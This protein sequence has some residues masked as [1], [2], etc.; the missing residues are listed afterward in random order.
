MC[1]EN[2]K[3]RVFILDIRSVFEK[4]LQI[5]NLPTK[6]KTLPDILINWLR[7][8]DRMFFTPVVWSAVGRQH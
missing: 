5:H 7:S 8:Q 1:I 2:H 6:G 4:Y 3:E